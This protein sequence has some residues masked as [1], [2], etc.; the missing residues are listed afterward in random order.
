VV[1][2]DDWL[3]PLAPHTRR[4]RRLHPDDEARRAARDEAKVLYAER[5]YERVRARDRDRYQR[6]AEEINRRRRERY[7]AKKAGT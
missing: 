3:P 1:E 6:N 4:P 2:D 5:N 7:W